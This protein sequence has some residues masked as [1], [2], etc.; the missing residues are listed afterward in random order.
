MI[1]NLAKL[2]D[3]KLGYVRLVKV[4]YGRLGTVK[5]DFRFNYED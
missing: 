1:F 3:N 5:L 4:K 2:V